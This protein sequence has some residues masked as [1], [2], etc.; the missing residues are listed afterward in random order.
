MPPDERDRILAELADQARNRFYGKYRG[1]V[2]DNQDPQGMG[3]LRVTVPAVLGEEPSPWALPCAPFTGDNVG[4]FTVPEVDAC[5][6]VEF[7]GGMLDY[8]IW[9]GGWWRQGRTPEDSGG[10]TGRPTLK[11]IRSANGLLLSM[12]D[13]AQ[14]IELGD[15]NG[16]NLLRIEVSGSQIVVEAATKAVVQAQQIELVQ[17]AAHPLAFGD[18]LLT[19]LQNL[20]TW[21]QTHVHPGEMAAGV[22]PVTPAP[23]LPPPPMPLPTMLSQRVKTG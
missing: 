18:D 17:G 5:V 21:L 7:E 9:T 14:V 8:P 15:E 13:D 10:D 2:F 11:V 19:Y 12:D 16:R 6:W 23:P 22:L 3:R 4:Q 1:I 20:T